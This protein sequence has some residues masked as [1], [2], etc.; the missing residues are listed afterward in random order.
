M[1]VLVVDD[2]KSIRMLVSQSLAEL[3]HEVIQADTGNAAL[4]CIKTHDIDLIMMDVEMPGINGFETTR[5]IR[6]LRGS[7]DWFPIIFLTT[8]IDDDS[9]AAG[10]DAGGD[11]Y[12]TKPITPRRLE[13]QIVAMERIYEMRQK[14][15]AFRSELLKANEA[16]SHASLHDQL[17]GLANR[18]HF[19]VAMQRE[20]E[21]AKREK[22]PLTLILCDIDF[23]KVYNDLNGHMAGDECLKIVA[24][25]IGSVPNRATDLACRYGGEE[26]AVI[27]PNTDWQGGKVLGE[28]IREAVLD[29]KSAHPGSK[30]H[31]CVTLS[32]G[33]ATYNGQYRSIEEMKQAADDAL[34]LSKE[35]GR[36]RLESA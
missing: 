33:L 24:K 22:E 26:F 3:E 20:F 10:I 36:N 14:L 31:D 30:V 28:K 19:D 4:D 25:A 34:Y 29:T 21:R 9:Y 27:L 32:L 2:S 5:A 7:D 13:K 16:L 35:N 15:N 12:L 1:K 11:A 23:F 17:T 18:R 8:K 6:S